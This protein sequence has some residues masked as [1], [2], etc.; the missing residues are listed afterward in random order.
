MG[1][2]AARELRAAEANPTSPARLLVRDRYNIVLDC[3][4]GIHIGQVAIGS[5][6][7]GINTAVGDAVNIAFRIETLTRVVGRST[8][9]STAFL[10]GWDEGR[11]HFES[12]GSHYVKGQNDPI[13]V[14]APL[15]IF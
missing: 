2:Q 9:V 13:E 6:G 1:E 10:D 7:K 14:F 5:M 15:A 4:I 8:L 3:R 12:C 11:R